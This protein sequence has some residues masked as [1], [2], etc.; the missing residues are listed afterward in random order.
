[1]FGAC[2]AQIKYKR[3]KAFLLGGFHLG[4]D[5]LLRF[6]KT[7]QINNKEHDLALVSC[8]TQSCNVRNMAFLPNCFARVFVL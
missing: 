1:M 6:S 4:V 3:I 2:V 8:S 5:F 7:K